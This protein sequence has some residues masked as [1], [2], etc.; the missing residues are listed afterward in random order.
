MGCPSRH[1]SA[2]NRPELSRIGEFGP[3]VAPSQTVLL[4]VRNLDPAGERAGAQ[5]GYSRLHDE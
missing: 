5:L 2:R 4:G 3:K 1:S